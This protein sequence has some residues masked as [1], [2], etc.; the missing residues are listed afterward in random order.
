MLL[1]TLL[2]LAVTVAIF[3][4]TQ[5][6]ALITLLFVIAVLVL[7]YKRLPLLAFSVVF[8]VLLAAYLYWG[9]PSGLWKGLLLLMLVGMWLFNLRPLRKALISRPFLKAYLRMLPT[10]SATER[11]GAGGRQV[12]WDGELFTGKPGLEPLLDTQ[13]RQRSPPRSR[14]S[15][16]A[17]SKSCAAMLDDWDITHRR[18]DLPPEVWEFLKRERFFGHDHPRSSMAAWNSRRYAHVLRAGEA[19]QPQ[20]HRSAS[21]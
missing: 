16:T 15:S 7:A 13:P 20:R 10:M 19:G 6:G 2:V 18:A 12:W 9:N 4:A 21:P 8:S 17:R 11:D 1:A 5:I 3:A 14:P